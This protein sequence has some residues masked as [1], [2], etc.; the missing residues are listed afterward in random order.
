MIAKIVVMMHVIMLAMA[1]VVVNTFRKI[2]IAIA[3]FHSLAKL[4]WMETSL[5]ND[6]GGASFNEHK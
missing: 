4:H 5:K 3:K 6:L 2:A 1:M